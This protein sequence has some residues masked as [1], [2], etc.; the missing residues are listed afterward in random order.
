MINETGEPVSQENMMNIFDDW[1][2]TAPDI[3]TYTLSLHSNSNHSI[4]VTFEQL[5]ERF[6][7]DV[8]QVLNNRHR[9]WTA[10]EN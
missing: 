4:I 1:S 3:K 10:Y 6:D 8:Y 2:K 9:Y 7:D 5:K